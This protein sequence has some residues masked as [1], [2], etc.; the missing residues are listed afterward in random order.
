MVFLGYVILVLINRPPLAKADHISVNWSTLSITGVGVL[1][2]AITL[3][4]VLSLPIAKYVGTVPA[5]I[6]G[7]EAALALILSAVI[8]YQSL[9][10]F[11][12]A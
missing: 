5:S 3:V 12:F 8:L 11:G 4:V 2:S 7:V 6:I 9:K 10:F 1:G